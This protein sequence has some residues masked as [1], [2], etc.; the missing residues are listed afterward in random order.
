[1]AIP[2][3]DTI[4]ILSDNLRLRQ[5]VMPIPK[6]R[7]T[8]WAKK[9]NLPRGGPT[10]IYTG[11]MYQLI[12]YIETMVAAQERLASSPLAGMTGLG[13]RMNRFVNIMRFMARPAA[14]TAAEYD[15]VLTDIALLLQTAGVDFGYLY[16]DDL[17]SGALAHDLG[18]DAV[19]ALHARRVLEAFKRHGVRSVITVD[20][21]T[22]NMLRTVYPSLVDGFTVEVKSY[23]EVLTT[24]SLQIRRDQTKDLVIHD[25]CV[26]ARYEGVVEEPRQ[27]LRAAG[28]TLNEPENTGRLTW[29]CGGPV[30]SLYPEKALANAQ[31]RVDQLRKAGPEGV[32]MC[33]L[34]LANLRRGAAGTMQFQDISRYLADAYV[35]QT[36]VS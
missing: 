32:T 8:G 30:E 16:E 4:G 17:Y 35:S 9:L 21:H 31:R 22:T 2:T 6:K 19:V 33:P 26:L 27:L 24:K 14:S 29:C 25:S 7:A 3:G 13:R 36:E 20:P 10:V 1:M 11:Q 34:C 12:P 5:S 28:V 23:L 15:R 18:L